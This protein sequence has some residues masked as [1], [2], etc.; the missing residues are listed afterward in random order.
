MKNQCYIIGKSL[1]CSL[2]N[3]K[4]DILNSLKSINQT[5]Y[6]DF[7]KSTFKKMPFYKISGFDLDETNRFFK[8][9]QKTIDEALLETNLSKEEQE[10][11]HIFIGS[12]SMGISINE[13]INKNF[14]DKE[15]ENELQYIGYGYI[16]TYV[17]RYLNS[18]YKT[19]IFST[20]CTSSVNAL[21]YA[22]KL[23]E[24]KKIKRAIIIGIE[25]F[26][27]ST[28]QGFSSLMLLSKEQVYRPF[29]KRSDGLILGE[30]CSAIILDSKKNKK[31]DF[32]YISSSNI[33]DNYSETTSN[34]SGEPI[35]KCVQKT[36]E[37]A[38]LCL[39]D[40]DLIKVHATGSE[41]NNT[42]ELN[43]LDSLFK[44]YNSTTNI[45][46]L[47]PYIGHTLG[48]SGTNEITLCLFA[49]E[50]GIILATLGFEESTKNTQIVPITKN[51]FVDKE[52]TILFNFVAFSGNN[53]SIILSNKI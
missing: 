27:K 44:K 5:N 29:D 10:D 12:T 36:I 43:A 47:K 16:G 32:R 39:K 40:I 19:T 11:L 45:T 14:H 21:A 50:E 20:A 6:I 17:E 35:F 48:A 33:C 25:L 13:Y 46:A 2:G 9:L 49:I 41:N 37:K 24:Q 30:G 42:S 1:C 15:T 4:K 51:I 3:T 31:N 34:P 52:Y 53:S 8:I 22:S 18:K 26:N 28:F 7:L 23:I 38:Q